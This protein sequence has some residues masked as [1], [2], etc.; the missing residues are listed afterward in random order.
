MFIGLL[1]IG[2]F[3][4]N[5]KEINPSLLE[6]IIDQFSFEIDILVILECI[7]QELAHILAICISVRESKCKEYSLLG[8]SLVK[9]ELEYDFNML[10]ALLQFFKWSWNILPSV[11]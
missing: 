2:I 3:P 4:G 11:V 9:S 1:S 5:S 7:L 10:F 6:G 8:I